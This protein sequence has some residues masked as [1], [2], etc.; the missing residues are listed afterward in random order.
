MAPPAS[1]PKFPL[2]TTLTLATVAAVL[3]AWHWRVGSPPGLAWTNLGDA[4]HLPFVPPRASAAKAPEPNVRGTGQPKQTQNQPEQP[5]SALLID[6]G[7]SM[8]KFYASLARLESHPPNATATVIHF[9]DSPTTAD[10]ITGD[11]REQLQQRFG[12]A[13][14]GFNLIAKPWAW[15]GHRNIDESDQGWKWSTAVGTMREGPYGIGGAV[16]DGSAGA[17]SSFSLNGAP[18][19]T[20]EFLFA[21]QPDGGS[22]SVAAD[23]QQIVSIDT[24]KPEPMP[25]FGL[26]F[27]TVD[28]PQGTHRVELKVDSGTVHLYGVRF[29]RS[30]LGLFYDSLGLNGASTTV[31]SRAMPAGMLKQSFDRLH[32]DLVVINYGT[33]EASFGAFVDK[34]YEGELRTAIARIRAAAPNASILVM[35]PMDRGERGDGNSIATMAT[36]PRLVAIQQRVAGET[37]CGFFN[38][39]EAMGGDGTMQRWYTSKPRLVGGDLIHPTPA[40][41]RIVADALV[42]EL[43]KGY[44]RYK[45]RI[46]S[47]PANPNPTSNPKGSSTLQAPPVGRSVSAAPL[48]SGPSA[49]LGVSASGSSAGLEIK[50]ANRQ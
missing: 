24:S 13:G 23:G 32:P 50:G 31:L 18:Q 30:Q 40:G 34:Q 28:L 15:Y 38:T 6:N 9:G 22:F 4:F 48:N 46:Q 45:A 33:N 37:G 26:A 19:S 5:Q 16:F 41:A 36:I 25:D 27:R 2:K 42:S 21:T 12:D 3:L 10:L 35:S 17:S 20:A 44:E 47:T 39:F 43:E 7:G 11:V 29:G 14:Q 1:T 49:K 8:D